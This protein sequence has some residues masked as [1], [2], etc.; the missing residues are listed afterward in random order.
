MAPRVAELGLHL[1]QLGTSSTSDG[2][3]EIRASDEG[4]GF[5]EKAF[6]GLGLAIIAQVTKMPSTSSWLG[7][8]QPMAYEEKLAER[9]RDL[10]ADEDGIAEKKMFGGLA[11][12]LNGNMAVAASGRGG[13]LVRVNPVDSEA[14][15]SLPNVELMQM[16]GRTM[17]GWI[18]VSPDG[19][20][21]KRELAGWVRRGIGYAKRLPSK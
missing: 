16:R 7:S 3:L 2:L 18:A 17:T 12:L 8:P 11:F 15:I 6:D 13:L 10:L 19:L 14:L 20:K 1:V 5:R 4:L 9:V 21:S